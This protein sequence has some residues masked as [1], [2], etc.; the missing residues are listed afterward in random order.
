MASDSATKVATQQSIK[1]YVDDS[2]DADMDLV[3]AADSGG[4]LN[5]VM[6]SE[7]L[8]L[9][10]GTGITTSG[11]SNTVTFAINNTVATLTGSETLT[12]KTFTSPTLNVLLHLL[13]QILV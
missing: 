12:N 1:A 4:S 5:I 11:S 9:T 7:S 8:T 2:I 6:D 3:F 13:E 10:G